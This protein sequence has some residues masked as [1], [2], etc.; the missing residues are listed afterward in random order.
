MVCFHNSNSVFLTLSKLLSELWLCIPLH[1]F[2]PWYLLSDLKF[3]FF[4]FCKTRFLLC[5]GSLR[6]YFD[7]VSL[8]SFCLLTRTLNGSWH[9]N[10]WQFLTVI[11][12]YILIIL[13]FYNSKSHQPHCSPLFFLYNSSNF[14]PLILNHWCLAGI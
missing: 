11:R 3:Q 2:F 9:G 5:S 10:I 1:F 4:F 14:L 12:E 13:C 6:F 8:A 7:N